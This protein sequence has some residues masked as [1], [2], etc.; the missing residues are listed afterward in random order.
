MNEPVDWEEEEDRITPRYLAAGDPTGWFEELYAAGESGRI[1]MPFDREEPHP[2]LVE[3]SERRGLTGFGEPAIVVGCGLGADAEYVAGR[4][5]RT[6]GFDVSKA[7][8]RIARRRH[9]GSSVDY[10]VADLLEL[11]G[12]WLRAFALVV[13]IITV[14]A[15]PDPP[16][17]DAIANVSRLVGDDGTLFVVAASHDY[18]RVERP[19]PWPLRREEVD[20]FATDGLAPVLVEA[21]SMPGD[22]DERR[23]RAEFHRQRASPTR[24]E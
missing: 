12:K 21:A 22:P 24:S 20:A 4:G 2:L 13:E 16:R 23:W 3:W 11:P 1:T 19:P 10:V 14:Q 15:L 9:P 7:A 6:T 5:F 17:R 8:V 18:S